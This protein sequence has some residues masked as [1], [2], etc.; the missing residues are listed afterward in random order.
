MMMNEQGEERSTFSHPHGVNSLLDIL[1]PPFLVYDP[2]IYMKI[3]IYGGPCVSLT[4]NRHVPSGVCRSDCGLHL[5]ALFRP[6]RSYVI[7]ELS[8][9]QI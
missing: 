9:T 2:T 5:R 1:Y 4:Q 7:M 8:I 6:C 3:S